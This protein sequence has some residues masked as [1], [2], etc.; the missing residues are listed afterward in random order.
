MKAFLVYT[1]V[2]TLLVVLYM[3]ALAHFIFRRVRT[4]LKTFTSLR[5]G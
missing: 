3:V 2:N 5:T 4:W 1:L